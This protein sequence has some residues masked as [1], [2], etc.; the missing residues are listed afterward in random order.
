M[1]HR[2]DWIV[3]VL[4]V[5]ALLGITGVTSYNA[6]VAHGVVREAPQ[7]GG[8]VVAP[9]AAPPVYYWHARPWGWG[10]FPF[11]PLWILIFWFFVF[12]GLC[13]RRRWYGPYGYRRWYGEGYGYPQDV[14]PGFD[15]WHRRAHARPNAPT[16]APPAEPKA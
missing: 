11:F 1:G 12:R 15:E 14:P 6:G 10:F 7:S 9:D 13:W 8:A 5:V 2:F 3:I 4:V 16:D